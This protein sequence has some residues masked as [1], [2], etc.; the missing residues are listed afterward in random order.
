MRLR[1]VLAAIAPAAA[2]SLIMV[3]LDLTLIASPWWLRATASMLAYAGYVLAIEKAHWVHIAARYT[4]LRRSRPKPV[5]IILGPDGA[6]KSTLAKTLSDALP[7]AADS[8]YLGMGLKEPWAF[9]IVRSAYQF[10]LERTA[11]LQRALTGLAVWYVLMPIEFLA[12]RRQASRGR[13]SRYVIIDRVPS[14]PFLQG[15]LLGAY[16]RWILP[17]ADNTVL[18]VGDA[19]EIASRK[20]LETSLGRTTLDLRKWEEVANRIARCR[21]IRLDTTREDPTSCTAVLLAAF[22]SKP[23]AKD[24]A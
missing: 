1:P 17:S 15:G 22:R 6:G 12:R 4:G 14:R 19:V 13:Q 2:G 16:Y 24:A 23:A 21:V 11:G 18:L 9:G 5:M 3:A 7:E 8:L 10:H 20:P